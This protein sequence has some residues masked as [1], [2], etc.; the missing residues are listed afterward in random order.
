MGSWDIGEQMFYHLD[1]MRSYRLVICGLCLAVISCKG[2]DPHAIKPGPVH[3][4][5][6]K[7][8]EQ[9]TEYKHSGEEFGLLSTALAFKLFSAV[10]QPGENQM[11]SPIS[12]TMVLGMIANGAKGNTQ[13]EILKALHVNGGVDSVNSAAYT[14]MLGLHEGSESPVS[15]SNGV[16]MV[17]IMPEPVFVSKIENKFGGRVS[18]VAIGKEGATEINNWTKEATCGMIDHVLDEVSPQDVVVLVNATAFAGSWAHQFDPAETEIGKF[19]VTKETT[20]DAKFMKMRKA[21]FPHAL[22]KDAECLSMR[23]IISDY[24]M[25]FM[26]P[27]SG[28]PTDFLAKQTWESWGELLGSL[29]ER[30]IDVEIPKMKF[31]NHIDLIPA[32]KK[33]GFGA[34]FRGADFSGFSSGAAG[35]PLSKVLHDTYLE[36]DEKGT[37][38]VAT[39]AV[40]KK[41]LAPSFEADRPFAFAI[42]HRPTGGILFLGV[43]N[44]PTQM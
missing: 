24:S 6:R 14:A 4:W 29:K 38:A 12:I 30:E 18:D 32:L 34:M 23:Y 5:A 17:S 15:I 33:T 42:V 26:L 1:R 19:S 28:S 36:V 7:E 11:V 44:D 13:T 10:A 43:C 16:W 31:R 27:R 25:V 39:T 22:T 37:S 40:F 35:S 2:G 8:P 3:E 41:A 9:S 20:V 21:T